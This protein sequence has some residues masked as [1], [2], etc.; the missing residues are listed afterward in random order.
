MKHQ[1]MKHQLTRVLLAA[2]CGAAL[3]AS[4]AEAQNQTAN[5]NIALQ[6][7]VTLDPPSNYE[8]TKDRNPQQ[9]TDGV[10]AN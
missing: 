8:F 9:L 5:Q 7:K 10:Y 2:T 4:C 1:T 6:K 3:L